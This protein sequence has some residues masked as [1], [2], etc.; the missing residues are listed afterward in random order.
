M[1]VLFDGDL[2]NRLRKRENVTFSP[3]LSIAYHLVKFAYI[4]CKSTILF[5]DMRC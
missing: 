2:D 5:I 1:G 4:S 3:K